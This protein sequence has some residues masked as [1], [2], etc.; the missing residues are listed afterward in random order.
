MLRPRFPKEQVPREQSRTPAEIVNLFD[1]LELEEP[2]EA[3]EQ[4]PDLTP[5]PSTNEPFYKAERQ[6]DIE[7]AFFA[8]HLLLG[9]LDKLRTE[10]SHA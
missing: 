2:S 3:F 7:E 5:A 10:V 4:A 1:H 9:D 6:D 8:L